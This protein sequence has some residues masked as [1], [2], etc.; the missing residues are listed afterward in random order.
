MHCILLHLNSL[1]ST[2]AITQNER[3]MTPKGIAFVTLFSLF[4]CLFIFNFS[5]PT[6]AAFNLSYRFPN[7]VYIDAL[8]T[9]GHVRTGLRR[10]SD[11]STPPGNT[12]RSSGN[13]SSSTSSASGSSS[14]SSSRSIS[15]SRSSSYGSSDESGS[16]SGPICA[17]F[18][19]TPCLSDSEAEAI[20]NGGCSEW[21]NI[22][23]GGDNI[24]DGTGDTGIGDGDSKYYDVHSPSV[25]TNTTT[26]TPNGDQSPWKVFDSS[27]KEQGACNQSQ[28]E[29]AGHAFTFAAAASLPSSASS[30][31]P[32]ASPSLPKPGPTSYHRRCCRNADS[33]HASDSFAYADL[34]IAATAQQGCAIFASKSKAAA[35]R[36]AAAAATGSEIVNPFDSSSSS[37]RGSSGNNYDVDD[38]DDDAVLAACSNV[39]AH[40]AAR[41]WKHP[42]NLWDDPQT[43]RIINWPEGWFVNGPP[44]KE[45]TYDFLEPGG[46]T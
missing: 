44:P 19:W 40:A 27:G 42:V 29:E 28:P 36:T 14:A 17:L 6:Q 16:G 24:G 18:Q 5:K 26:T 38:N 39:A 37:S 3:L 34:L 22:N 46:S 45:D 8:A 30:S 9:G 11:Q 7:A 13:N 20:G 41:Y 25:A 33:N 15:I 35:A 21:V 32:D 4:F 2:E 12:S 31:S 10:L 1:H 23:D 43:G